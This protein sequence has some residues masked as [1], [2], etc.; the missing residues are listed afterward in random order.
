MVKYNI[1]R[2]VFCI[3]VTFI[4]GCAL[5]FMVRTLLPSG[6][7]SLW[8]MLME[9]ISFAAIISTF[10]ISVAWKWPIFKGWLIPIPDLNGKWTGRLKYEWEGQER[11]RQ[12]S[13]NIKQTLF[14]IIIELETKESS[15]R[16][17]CGTF[18]I[19]KDKHIKDLIYSYENEPKAALRN[20]SPIHYGTARLSINDDNTVMKGEYW[21]SR[22]TKGEMT[23]KKLEK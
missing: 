10:F 7:I 18:D 19:D 12:F 8:E 16:N 13:A 3:V 11:T 23:L 22:Q 6:A 17:F 15:S 1:K 5:S 14:S 20:R 21:T 2:F 9:G 4:V